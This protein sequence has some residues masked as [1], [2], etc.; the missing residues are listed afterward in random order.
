MDTVF[1]AGAHGKT[2]RWIVEELSQDGYKVHALVHTEEQA[3]TLSKLGAVPYIGDLSGTFSEGMKGAAAV[4]CAVGAGASGDPEE[5]DHTGTIRLI[6]Q[7]GLLRIP[8]FILISSIGTLNPDGMPAALKPYL[9]AKRRAEKA[10]EESLLN[11]TIIRPGELTDDPPK[12]LVLLDAADDKSVSRRIS[13]Q[14]VAR[15]AV[16]ALKHPQTEKT[17]FD[18]IEGHIPLEEALLTLG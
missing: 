15:A 13:R 11:H 4:I 16:L 2:G 1:V 3:N 10:L 17:S 18:L 8:R 7:S 14:D 5:V 12:G 9:L 6:E